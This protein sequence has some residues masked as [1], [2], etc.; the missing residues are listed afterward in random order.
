[1]T[2]AQAKSK[3]YSLTV[4]V[5]T[6]SGRC[7]IGLGLDDIGPEERRFLFDT[8]RR[9]TEGGSAQLGLHESGP[10][11]KTLSLLLKEPISVEIGVTAAINGSH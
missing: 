10:G 7:E 1:M 11:E 6:E 5:R 9:T 8:L 4:S 2:R 3:A